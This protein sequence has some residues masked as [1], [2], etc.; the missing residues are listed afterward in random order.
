MEED[1]GGGGRGDV[2][3][4]ALHIRP[5]S[6]PRRQCVSHWNSLYSL[7]LISLFW[8]ELRISWLILRFFLYVG[9]CCKE[10]FPAR[11]WSLLLCWSLLHCDP[12][13]R[14]SP[15]LRS[16]WVFSFV[17]FVIVVEFLFWFVFKEP[18]SCMDNLATGKEI[19]DYCISLVGDCAVCFEFT[20]YYCLG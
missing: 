11:S 17:L 3:R 19:F 4:W 12:W 10:F 5:F 2:A 9:Y 7:L 14:C 1:K 18:D 16:Y 13:C 6:F 20:L 15:A 8:W